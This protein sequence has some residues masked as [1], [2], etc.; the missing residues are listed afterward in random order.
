MVLSALSS[1]LEYSIRRPSLLASPLESSRPD[2]NHLAFSPL[3]QVSIPFRSYITIDVSYQPSPK[4]FK[5]GSV[6]KSLSVALG[7]S[8]MAVV[9]EDAEYQKQSPKKRTSHRHILV[10]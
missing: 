5:K 2:S 9:E 1:L 3:E 6:S 7:G 8:W 10:T 4:K